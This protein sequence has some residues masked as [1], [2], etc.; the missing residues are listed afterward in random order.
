MNRLVRF[1]LLILAG[2]LLS[3]CGDT[4]HSPQAAR[5]VKAAI[6]TTALTANQNIAG[7][8]LAM[9]LPP[10][11]TP[12]LNADGKVNIA[13]TVT[14]TSSAAANQTLPGATYTPA[15]A[16]AAGQLAI[17]AIVASGFSVNDEITIHLNI[18]DAVNPVAS[19]FK[20][21]A[22]KAYSGVDA[23]GNGG[24]ILYDMNVIDGSNAITLTPTLTATIL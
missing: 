12:T 15:T 16:S 3:A 7:I 23:S 13:A 20:L 10:G 8:E 17:S 9:T 18:A 6:K 22:F 4:P 5:T 24:A 21:L 19:D 1:I 2:T 11:I 14:I